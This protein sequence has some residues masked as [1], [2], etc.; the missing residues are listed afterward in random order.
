MKKT[1]VIKADLLDFYFD[2]DFYFEDIIRFGNISVLVTSQ[3]WCHFSLSD[4][5]SA[6]TVLVTFQ[7][8]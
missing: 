3:F 7:F 4:S 5:F 6:I 8:W 1:K 2:I